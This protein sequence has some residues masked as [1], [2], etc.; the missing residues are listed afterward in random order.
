[1]ET[2]D[3]KPCPV[4]KLEGQDVVLEADRGERITYNCA[5][6]GEFTITRVAVRMVENK[7]IGSKLSSWI[8]NQNEFGI[9]VP[10]INSNSLTEI[11]QSIP[12]YTPSDKQQLFLRNIAIKSN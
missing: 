5:R 4:C 8:R 9:V 12:D 2:N 10:E 11:V 1:M 6:C 3:S 7:K